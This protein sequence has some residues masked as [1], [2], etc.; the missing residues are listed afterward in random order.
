M[1]DVGRP[2]ATFLAQPAVAV[3]QPA[4]IQA[5]ATTGPET[6]VTTGV[7]TVGYWSWFLLIIKAFVFHFCGVSFFI[8]ASRYGILWNGW[9]IVFTIFQLAV[10]Y[11]YSISSDRNRENIPYIYIIIIVIVMLLGKYVIKSSDYQC[12]LNSPIINTGGGK[13]GGS[14]R[15]VGKRGGSKRGGGKRVK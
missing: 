12:P 10:L 7:A 6:V 15:G 1:G 13:R 8:C 5:V 9:F 4:V 2:L 3:A 14:K 11:I